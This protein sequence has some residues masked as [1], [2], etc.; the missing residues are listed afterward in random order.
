MGN[1]LLVHGAWVNSSCW[2]CDTPALRERGHRVETVEL[3]RG[4]LAAD[5]NAAQE[6][7]DSLGTEVVACGWSYG[8]M[9][10]TGLDVP[11]GSYLVY[12]C[13]FMPDE[14]E[15]ASVLAE[16][17]PGDIATLFQVDDAGNLFVEGDEVD[18]F[19]WADAPADRAAPARASLRP[20]AMQTFVDTPARVSW[21]AYRPHT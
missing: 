13:A 5:T 21:R 2:D 16:R 1:V 3:H 7:V 18:E 9:V 20:Q 19:A 12:L 4:T 14:G 10:I 6:T 11:A 8:G 15:S 17:H